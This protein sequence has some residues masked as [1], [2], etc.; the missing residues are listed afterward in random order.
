MVFAAMYE[1]SCTANHSSRLAIEHGEGKV[2]PSNNIGTGMIAVKQGEADCSHFSGGGTGG[3]SASV[4]CEK[5]LHPAISNG[6]D[7]ELSVLA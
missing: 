4:K 5:F 3:L 7:H 1:K 2:S 6:T